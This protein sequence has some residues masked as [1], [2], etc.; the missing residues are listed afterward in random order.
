MKW[1]WRALARRIELNMEKRYLWDLVEPYQRP[2]PLAPFLLINVAG[3]YTGLVTAA[4]SEQLYKERYWE[5]HPGQAV[6]IMQPLLY[7]GPY[8]VRRED[9]SDGSK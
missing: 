1:F 9:F 8:K 4:V 3:F 6:P 7:V 5:E 2:R